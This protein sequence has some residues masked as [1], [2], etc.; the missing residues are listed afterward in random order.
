MQT[1]LDGFWWFLGASFAFS[2][3]VVVFVA[4]CLILDECSKMFGGKP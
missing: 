4:A 2:M 1:F 3:C